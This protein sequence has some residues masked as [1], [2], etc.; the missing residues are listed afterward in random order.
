MRRNTGFDLVVTEDSPNHIGFYQD[1]L[2]AFSKSMIERNIE[3]PFMCQ[4]GET[5]LGTGGSNFAEILD[6]HAAVVFNA[7]RVGHGYSLT[8]HRKLGETFRMQQICIELCPI[9]NEVLQLCRNIKEHP[10]PQLLAMGIPCT[11]NADSPSMY[12]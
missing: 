5:R 10:Y 11:L 12:R 1:E 6:L 7:K 9:S 3:L 4:A 8:T 2:L